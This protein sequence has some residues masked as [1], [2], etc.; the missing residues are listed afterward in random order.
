[1]IT[2]SLVENARLH[3]RRFFHKHMPARLRF[4]NLEHTLSVAEAAKAIGRASG[5]KGNALLLVEVAALFHDTG[6]ADVYNG[7]EAESAKHARAWLH[8]AGMDNRT[9]SQVTDLILATSLLHRPRTLA[10]RVIRDADSAKAGQADFIAKGILLKAEREALLGK[11][12]SH[13]T[14]RKE[15]LEYLRTHQFHTAYARQRF[16]RQKAINLHLL[17]A[18][19]SEGN[20][21]LPEPFMD[22]DLSWLAFNDRVLQEAQNPHV[23]LLERL[24][25]VAIHSSNLDEFY[26]VRVAQL[27]SLRK[28]G[29]W[30]RSAL[31]VPPDKHIARINKVALKQQAALGSVYRNHLLPALRKCGI[32]IRNEKQLTKAQRHHVLE[33]FH[34]AVAPLLRPIALRGTNAVLIEDRK[35]Y[36]VFTFTHKGNHRPKPVVV[37]VPSADLGRFIMLP[38]HRGGTDLMY[39]DDVIRFGASHLFRGKIIKGCYAI[40]LSR[41][42]DLYLDEEFTEDVAEKVRKSLRKRSTGL[43]ARF[44][45]DGRMPHALLADLRRMMDIKKTGTLEGGRYHNLSDLMSVPIS[46]HPELRDA[47]MPPL[48]HPALHRKSPFRAMQ[49]GDILV[50]I[51]YQDFEHITNLLHEAADDPEVRRIAIT[52]YRVAQSSQICEALVKAARNGKRVEVVMEVQARFD[53]GNNLHWASLLSESGAKVS[54]GVA[55]YK[56]HAKLLLLERG[57]VKAIKRYALLGTGNFNEQTARI[58]GDMALLTAQASITGEVARIFSFL[59]KGSLPGPT[60]LL[61]TSPEQLRVFL[62]KAIDYEI[63]QA[64]LGQPAEIFLKLN[65][66][67]DKSLIRKLYDAERAGVKVR[68]IIR[69]ICCLKPGVPGHSTH[70]QAI[71]IVDRFLEHARVYVFNN[72][73]KPIIYLASADWMER[74]LDRR[75]E[76]AFPILHEHQRKE[77]LR[78]LELQW[79]DNVK[80]RILDP[81]QS[82]AYRKKSPKEKPVRA[83]LDWYTWL[84]ETAK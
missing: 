69:G 62:E 2:R 44:L 1:M 53:E 76:V 39:L 84:K 8:K 4:H 83:Q 21:P 48:H 30:N 60:E 50:H 15:N 74:N 61:A 73:G 33:H 49:A 9:V 14:W 26:R 38:S 24:K 58:Y 46:G 10:Q 17:E 6:Y 40:K 82:N 31:D 80:A 28:L 51:P 67:E 68:L 27:H 20:T 19:A 66:L 32:R 12:I 35:P 13:V 59:M 77:V 72:A 41:D 34:H 75:V 55:G 63:E 47:P 81:K 7:H 5:L 70:I 71:S 16:N 43:P 78:F 45:Y 42:A 57:P 54:Y 11:P 36:L 79:A 18:Q 29:K 23:P 22:R 65:S 56:V 3:V 37:N 25:F 64:F 52:L